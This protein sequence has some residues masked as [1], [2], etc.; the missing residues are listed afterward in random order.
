M[1][2]TMTLESGELALDPAVHPERYQGVRTRRSF[3]FLVDLGVVLFL[4]I[5]SW[6][7]IGVLG[8]FTLGVGWLLF[9]AVWPAVA[10]LYTV[11]TLG[12]PNS[13]TP[14]M[15]FTGVEM[16]TVRGEPMNYGLA[17][18]HG[19]GFWFS[20]GILTPLILVVALFTPRKQLLHDLLI[21]TVVVRSAF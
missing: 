4:M 10:I 15:R 9:P 16:R 5:V 12:G 17:L 13:A 14:G 6:I 1:A 7:V 2:H 19:L 20:V 21:G 18:L 11:L 3:A 8:V